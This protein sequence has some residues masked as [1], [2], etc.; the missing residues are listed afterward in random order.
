MEHL[1]VWF[2]V[3]VCVC[4]CVCVLCSDLS[5]V[6]LCSKQTLKKVTH[7]AQC[8]T[9]TTTTKEN[10]T[11]ISEMR[12]YLLLDTK[13]EHKFNFEFPGRKANTRELM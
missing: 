2:C 3:C 5:V 6:P 4:M 8:L 1:A 10:S 12:N 11:V 13:N 9:L 7:E